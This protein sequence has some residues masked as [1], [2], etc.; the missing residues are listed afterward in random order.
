VYLGTIIIEPLQQLVGF[1]FRL[2]MLHLGRSEA[3]EISH[4]IDDPRCSA[5]I[6]IIRTP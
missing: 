4:S 5:D 6:W 2:I 3:L 1:D